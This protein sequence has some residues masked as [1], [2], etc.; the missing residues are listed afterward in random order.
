Q[1]GSSPRAAASGL[2]TRGG[3]LFVLPP[4]RSANDKPAAQARVPAW[5]L[6]ALRACCQRSLPAERDEIA[7]LAAGHGILVA[8]NGGE[9]QVMFLGV[10]GEGA[11]AN[12]HLRQPAR[13]RFANA[14]HRLNAI[15]DHRAGVR[16][17]V[18]AV[19]D[20]VAGVELVDRPVLRDAGCE[21]LNLPL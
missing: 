5:P 19:N 17:G 9:P 14:D 11:A 18:D 8:D 3:R 13:A 1:V 15:A 7:G 21:V 6:L 16:D 12:I 4:T 2:A 20:V 10:S